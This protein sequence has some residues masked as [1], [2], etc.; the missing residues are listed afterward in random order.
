MCKDKIAPRC[1]KVPANCVHYEGEIPEF[2]TLAQ[3][4]C[5]SIQNTTED[6]YGI[7]QQIKDDSD[8]SDVNSDC[9]EQLQNPK[10]KT[11]VQRIMDKICAMDELLS[12]QTDIIGQMQQEITELQENC[13]N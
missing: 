3:D 10:I 2:S 13:G 1:K 5:N 6:I 7:L 8:L 4:D 12:E 11:L 9:F